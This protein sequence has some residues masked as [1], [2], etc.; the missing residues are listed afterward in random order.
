MNNTSFQKAENKNQSMVTSSFKKNEDVSFEK[1]AMPLRLGNTPAFN[2][3]NINIH[4]SGNDLRVQPKLQINQPGD[5]YEQEADAMADKVMRMNDNELGRSSFNPSNFHIQRKCAECEKEDEEKKVQRKE[6]NNSSQSVAPPVVYD[7]L[8]SSSGKRMDSTARLFMESRF[9]YD[10]GNIR[11]HD[12]DLAAKSANSINALAYTYGNNIVFNSARYKPHSIE[13]KKLLAHELTH[14]A[15]QRSANLSSYSSRSSNKS[16]TNASL[17][18]RQEDVE[19]KDKPTAS[20]LVQDKSIR[21]P[22]EAALELLKRAH[23]YAQA[24]NHEKA[25]EFLKAIDKFIQMYKTSPNFDKWFADENGIQKTA[26]QMLI[27]AAQNAPNR[28]LLEYRIADQP[29]EGQWKYEISSFSAA[30]PYLNILTG[31]A[32]LSYELADAPYATDAKA[33]VKPWL[34]RYR[35]SIEE[36][37]S[38]FKIDRRAIA[39][40]IAWEAIE[41]VRSAW[42][43]SSV[44][45]GKVHI[46]KHPWS[47]DNSN[48]V[49]KQ[50]EDEGY[51]PK[52]TGDERKKIL[53]QPSG[54][55]TY[56]GAIMKAGADIAFT[57]GGFDI[58]QNPEVLTWY[59]NS[60]DLVGWRDLIKN[61][62]PGVSFDTSKNRMSVW[63]KQNLNFLEDAVGKPTFPSPF[64]KQS[65]ETIQRKCRNEE[66][67]MDNQ[68]LSDGTNSLFES[69]FDSKKSN[70]LALPK[71]ARDFFE[72]RFEYDFTHVKIHTDSAANESAQSIN[73]FAYTIGDNIFFNSGQYN[74]NT[75]S[76]RK[77]LA[78]ELTH[79]VQQTGQIQRQEKDNEP[80]TRENQE[81]HTL[82]ELNASAAPEGDKWD[83]IARELFN[84]KDYQ[85]YFDS[86]KST[87]VT[88]LGQTVTKVH[89]ELVSMLQEVEKELIIQKGPNYK[90]PI[91]SSTLRSKKG[92][93]GW[94]MAID[95]DVEQNPYILNESG[96]A[97]L[98]L[99]LL[100]AYD[101]I[102]QFIL[103]KTE[104]DIHKLKKGRSG[105]GGT[106]DKVYD[107]LK[108]ESDAM[109]LYFSFLDNDIKLQS[110][111][112]NEWAK[113]NPENIAPDVEQLKLQIR[114]D[115]E[116]LGGATLTGKK[117]STE[118]VCHVN[119]KGEPIC[120]TPD[121]PFAP[122]SGGGKGDPEKGFLNLDKDFV[123]AMTEAGFAW[124]AIDI[125]GEPGD[126]QHFDLRLNGIG[127]KVL[128]KH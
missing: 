47:S 45:P 68:D 5:Q 38:K 74:P 87:S 90:A 1:N 14:V 48:T 10:F 92:M 100:T 21:P 56:I 55:I 119:K 117:R 65:V 34:Q 103:G 51:V 62:Q 15:Q 24:G 127:A 104:S 81:V 98:D 3:G 123:I 80:I 31:E 17:I 109:K 88:F 115:Y 13:G 20:G 23:M 125:Q 42:T 30:I 73:A 59:Y 44:G 106:I 63:V 28:L 25:K 29:S 126:I 40:A 66:K 35:T 64:Q 11:I 41:N 32:K 107:I 33:R 50:V 8:N 111:I 67:L 16:P 110:F 72:P 91:V 124:G 114:N 19:T 105:F 7:V 82:H 76:G 121:R 60:I 52:Q 116:I 112:N 36:A 93:H 84:K 69:V 46:R 54:A 61:K 101:H 83:R 89:P 43:P 39:G 58:S 37:E 27:N 9:N 79:V 75:D 96:E 118:P 94:G 77:L 70:E 49:A 6:N 99:E 113:K 86:I 71:A 108:D 128:Q 97:K 18:F 78:H 4:N 53:A 120:N 12:N 102:A 57:E 85:D 95:F 26:A 2:F 22:S 122:S